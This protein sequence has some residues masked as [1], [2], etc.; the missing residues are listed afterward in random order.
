MRYADIAARAKRLMGDASFH[1]EQRAKAEDRA[2][3]V[4]GARPLLE[5]IFTVMP[6][7]A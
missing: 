4:I 1:A 3:K 7:T 6:P 2:R 5:R